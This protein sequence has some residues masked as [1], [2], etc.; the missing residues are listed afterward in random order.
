M[1]PT[2]ATVRA[3]LHRR[4]LDD[5]A[6]AAARITLVTRERHIVYRVRS[7]KRHDYLFRFR[8]GDGLSDASARIQRRWLDAIARDTDIVAP[9][10][11]LLKG[12]PFPLDGD[13]R[14]SAMFTWVQGRRAPGANGFVKPAK[15]RAV[16]RAVAKLHRHA[17][18]FRIA[19]A[20]DL[21]RFDADFFFAA[22]YAR[23]P[24][25]GSSV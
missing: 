24:A 1:L 2:A 11:V 6:V 23:L 9:R 16:A 17:E 3:L 4:G 5:A 15:L 25:R 22:D 19:N 13:A 18:Q 7:G 14:Q 12:R 21:R 20:T 8:D 10:V